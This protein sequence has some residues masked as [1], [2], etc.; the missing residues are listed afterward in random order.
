[1]R[2]CQYRIGNGQTNPEHLWA[3]LTRDQSRIDGA[4]TVVSSTFADCGKSKDFATIRIWSP[5]CISIS[6]PRRPDASSDGPATLFTLF[7][8]TLGPQ[9]L[10]RG[11]WS[12]ETPCAIG[13]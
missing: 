11:A 2:I 9:S 8:L 3:R 10:S 5:D 1:M 4:C 13:F 12:S 7:T 6:N